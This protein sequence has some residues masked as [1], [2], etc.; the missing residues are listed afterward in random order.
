MLLDRWSDASLSAESRARCYQS[1]KKFA[2][3]A[4]DVEKN[5]YVS[6]C[7]K[8]VYLVFAKHATKMTESTLPMI[9]Q[10]LEEGP[11]LYT[12]DQKVS[13][14]HAQVYIHQLTS[15]LKSAK[16]Q[17]T[18]ESFK[19]I[20]TWQFVSCLDFWANAI[21]N[22]CNPETGVVSPMLTHLKPLVDLSLQTIR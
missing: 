20:Y 9:Q 11:D 18:A 6:H 10:M 4:I 22:T 12:L 19:T 16:K 21:A 3:T 2:A 17:H 13:S 5:S 14:Q 15:H 7:L 1:I 8:G